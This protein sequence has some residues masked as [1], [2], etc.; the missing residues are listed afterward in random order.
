[1]RMS[2]E[3]FAGVVDANLTG[4]YRVAKRATAGMLRAPRADDL[5]LVV[6]AFTGAPGPGELRG[7][8]S[9]RSS[10][11]P[12]RSRASWAA[13]SITANVIAP[14]FVDTDM[15]AEL[16]ETR[17]NE[18]SRVPLGRTARPTTSPRL[19]LPRS[20]RRYITGA[21]LPVDGGLGMGI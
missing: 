9:R 11:W 20:G 8:Q 17:R 4:A 12:G 3:S 14:G 10:A 13:A 2:E 15:T 21:V 19:R 7:Q 5:H 1:M 16:G 6:V 18:T